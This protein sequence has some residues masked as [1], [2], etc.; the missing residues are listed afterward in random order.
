MSSCLPV[1]PAL[2]LRETG[3][4]CWSGGRCRSYRRGRP[5]PEVLLRPLSDASVKAAENGKAAWEILLMASLPPPKR[6]AVVAV[7]IG[8]LLWIFRES[9]DFG[10]LAGK[11]N[12]WR[13]VC[14]RRLSSRPLV[15]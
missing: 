4:S 1:L 7:K 8:F 5:M 14:A 2:K 10:E 9:R 11:N 15:P 13:S 12:Y 6:V 3:R